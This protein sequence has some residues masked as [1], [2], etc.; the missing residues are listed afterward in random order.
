MMWD[1]VADA[2]PDTEIP[3]LLI[4]AP[5]VAHAELCARAVW[6]VPRLLPMQRKALDTLFSKNNKE[7][8]LLACLRTGE[9][10][11]LIIK[12]LGTLLHGVHLI[13]HPTLVLTADQVH[14]FLGC[15]E[16]HG[17]IIVINLDDSAGTT[18]EHR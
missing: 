2:A 18:P 10:K 8:K 14:S 16:A 1:E 15:N 6:N 12:L 3:D 17:T 7:K 9:G 4:D 5:I 13:V 11:S